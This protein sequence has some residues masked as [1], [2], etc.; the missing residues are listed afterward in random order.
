MELDSR[1]GSLAVYR[2]LSGSGISLFFAV[3]GSDD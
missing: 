2:L 1:L 3:T